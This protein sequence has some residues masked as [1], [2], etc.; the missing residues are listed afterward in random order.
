[1]AVIPDLRSLDTTACRLDQQASELRSR[2]DRLRASCASVQWQ[3]T[4]ANLFRGKCEVTCAQLRRASEQLD[5][6]AAVLRGHAA[7]AR[8]R[9]SVG[10]ALVSVG[11]SIVDDATRWIGL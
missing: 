8:E 11:A 6:A 1:M 9:L 4:A 5:H 2:A 7:T 3:S 10:H